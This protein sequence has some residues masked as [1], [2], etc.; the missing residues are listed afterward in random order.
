MVVYC[1]CGARSGFYDGV[2]C[3]GCWD[4]LWFLVVI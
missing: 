2:E 4:I 1:G 3:F